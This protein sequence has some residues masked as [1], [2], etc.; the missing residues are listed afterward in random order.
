MMENSGVH[1]IQHSLLCP[2]MSSVPLGLWRQDI[3]GWSTRAVISPRGAGG[4]FPPCQFGWPPSDWLLKVL[5]AKIP[6]CVG[7]STN[8]TVMHGFQIIHRH[9]FLNY[10]SSTSTESQNPTNVLTSHV[11]RQASSLPLKVPKSKSAAQPL[12]T[13]RTS[14][15]V[16][17]VTHVIYVIPLGLLFCSHLCVFS[18]TSLWEKRKRWKTSNWMGKKKYDT[19][20]QLNYAKWR[21]LKLKP[22]C[23]WYICL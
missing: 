14:W 15:L 6:Q 1:S 10:L 13:I 5:S 21:Q 12:L 16:S 2:L 23:L 11:I 18:I 7:K 4:T 8:T 19:T 22:N 9:S 17:N 3:T 20:R